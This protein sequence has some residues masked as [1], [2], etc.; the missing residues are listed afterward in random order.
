M[1]CYLCLLSLQNNLH[2]TLW[3][4]SDHNNHFVVNLQSH[5]TPPSTVSSLQAYVSLIVMACPEEFWELW[6]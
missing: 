6:F 4:S 1:L 2:R 5:L 3:L